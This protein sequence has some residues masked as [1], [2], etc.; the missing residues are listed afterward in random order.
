MEAPFSGVTL[1]QLQALSP[2]EFEQWVGD[3]FQQQG[4]YVRNTADSADHGVDLWLATPDGQ[5]AVAQCKR[6]NGTVG[7]PAVRDLYGVMQHEKA[8]LGFLVTTGRLSDSARRWAEGKPMVLLDGQQLIA[9]AQDEGQL[10]A[11]DARTG[12]QPM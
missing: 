11:A 1:A 5:T 8:A 2:A 7:E 6:Y 10:P 12:D 4:Y 9:M 3:R